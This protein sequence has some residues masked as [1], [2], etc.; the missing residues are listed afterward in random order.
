MIIDI[1]AHD[2][3]VTTHTCENKY[4]E[5]Y[6]AICYRKILSI[7]SEQNNNNLCLAVPL[8]SFRK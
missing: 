1:K 4:L 5:F 2:H 7:T 6:N 3:A 8:G